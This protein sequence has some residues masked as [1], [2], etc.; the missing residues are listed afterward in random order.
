MKGNIF[1]E[2]DFQLLLREQGQ[3]RRFISTVNLK[4]ENE[5]VLMGSYSSTA[6]NSSG[7]VV[8]TKGVRQGLKWSGV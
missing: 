2:K 6:A 4:V 3:H 8:L 5:N 1:Q 7:T